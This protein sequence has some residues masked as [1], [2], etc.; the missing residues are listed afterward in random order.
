MDDFLDGSVLD[1][2]WCLYEPDDI[3]NDDFDAQG[4]TMDDLATDSDFL[5]DFRDSANEE[6]DWDEAVPGSAGTSQLT[7]SSSQASSCDTGLSTLSPGSSKS[8]RSRVPSNPASL[9]QACIELALGAECYCRRRPQGISCMKAFNVGDIFRLRHA[10]HKMSFKESVQ[11]KQHDLEQAWASGRDSCRITVEGKSIC[12]QA[13]C[14]LYNLNWSSAR[15]SWAQL[16]DGQRRGA[17]G[18]PSGSSGGVLSS[19]KGLQ[20]YAWLKTWIELNGD[21]DPVGLKYK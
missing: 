1:V 10:R 21:E 2:D 19:A 17:V 9:S 3:P 12:L 6:F 8:P 15:R 7:S 4:L 20:A 13:Y 14:M 11:M 18:R 5:I 16:V